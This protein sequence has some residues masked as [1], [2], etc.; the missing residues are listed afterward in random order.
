MLPANISWHVRESVVRTLR[1]FTSL[2]PLDSRLGRLPSVVFLFPSVWVFIALCGRHTYLFRGIRVLRSSAQFS[3][4]DNNV[5]DTSTR[6]SW[7]VPPREL[8]NVESHPCFENN[9]LWKIHPG[10]L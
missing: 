6:V 5:T 3:L 10:E 2:H 1:R 7:Q 4:Y 8:K 9:L